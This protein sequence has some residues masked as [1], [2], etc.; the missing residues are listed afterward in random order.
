MRDEQRNS[1]RLVFHK[2]KERETLSTKYNN[3]CR[4]GLQEFL[5]RL[6]VYSFANLFLV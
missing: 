3:D 5:L 1:G 4:I 2:K 6:N